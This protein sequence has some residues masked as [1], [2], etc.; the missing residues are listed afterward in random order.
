MDQNSEKQR[1]LPEGVLY[2]ISSVVSFAADYLL[3]YL[4]MS[5]CGVEN[6][7][8]IHAISTFAS[9]VVNFNLNKFLVFKKQG[10]YFRDMISYYCVCLHHAVGT[11]FHDFRR[12]P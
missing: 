3:R 10:A 2:I 6:E 11:A 9:S 5:L 12:R 7:A 8:W 1:Q 4:L